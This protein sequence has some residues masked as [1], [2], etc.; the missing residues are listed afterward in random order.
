MPRIGLFIPCYVDQL[1]P[2]VG[3][4]TLHILKKLGTEIEF[5]EEQTC[6]GQPMAN[7]GCA[8]DAEP[9]ARRFLRIFK[10]YDVVVAPSGSCV[11][12]VRNHYH[13]WLEGEPGFEHLRTH[14]YELC[15]YLVEVAGVKLVDGEFAHRVGLHMSCHGIRELRMASGTERMIPP[16]NKVRGLLSQLRGIDIKELS[17]P[18]ECCGFGGTFSVTEEAV[19]SLMGRDR[20]ADHEHAGAE[21][22]AGFDMSCLMH[23]EGLIKRANKPMRVMHVAEI[24]ENARLS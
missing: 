14:T 16:F 17:R 2:Q 5:P 4:A 19:S 11:S 10:D 13:Q 23:M 9:L 15:E 21:V 6:C 18:D 8:R 24:L 1:Y 20:I 3:I 12:M 7:M 22:I